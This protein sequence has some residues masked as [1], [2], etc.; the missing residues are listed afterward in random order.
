[1][2]YIGLDAAKRH[3]RGFWLRESKIYEVYSIVALENAT[4]MVSA[5]ESRPAKRASCAIYLRMTASKEVFGVPNNWQA[6]LLFDFLP[7]TNLCEGLNGL[8]VR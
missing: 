8:S 2:E 6:V 7:N 1:M 4:A 5:C 3:G